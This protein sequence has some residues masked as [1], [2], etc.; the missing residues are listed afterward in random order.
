MLEDDWWGG[1][2]RSRRRRKR[3]EITRQVYSVLS[4]RNKRVKGVFKRRKFHFPV[5]TTKKSLTQN[6]KLGKTS[7]RQQNAKNEYLKTCKKK[8]LRAE[9]F[10]EKK[11]I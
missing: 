4:E 7:M 3:S 8:K 11:M 5:Q 6:K 10:G 1:G 2:R 9:S